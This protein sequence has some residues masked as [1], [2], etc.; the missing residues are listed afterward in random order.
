VYG[1][2]RLGDDPAM[3]P[4]VRSRLK[5]RRPLYLRQWREHRGLTQDQL[6]ERSG[7]TQGLISLLE[8]N[9]TDYSG[10]TL[11]QLAFGLQCE[12]ADL[13]MRNP[14][15]PDAPWTVYDTLSPVEKRQAVEI[16][17]GL[18]RASNN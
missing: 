4:K 18:K 17:K 14:T 15:D 8:R 6:A 1:S 10:E 2:R 16:M 13:L 5:Q 12:V 9:V 11:A 7:V 3:A